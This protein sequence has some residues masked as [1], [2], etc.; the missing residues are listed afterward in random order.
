MKIVFLIYSL[1]VNGISKS[2]LSLVKHIKQYHTDIEV[3]VATPHIGECVKL[4]EKESIRVVHYRSEKDLSS[5]INNGKFKPDL[6]F[7]E[8]LFSLAHDR[9]LTLF[10]CPIILRIHNELP[11]NA[12]NSN[13][14]TNYK[15]PETY[16][17]LL[18]GKCNVLIFTSKH[19]R[20]HYN[21]VLN[22]FPIKYKVIYPAFHILEDEGNTALINKD[23]FN[24]LQLGTIYK[25]KGCIQT[26]EAFN[27]FLDNQQC[28]DAKLFFFGIR[29]ASKSEKDYVKQVEYKI[30]EY[31]LRNYVK[32]YPTILETKSVINNI[33][34]LTLHSE[35][36]SFPLVVLEAMSLGKPIV[37]TDVGGLSE[38]ICPGI[39]GYL[40][41]FNDVFTQARLFQSIYEN[42]YVW[43]DK[44]DEIIKYY[45]NRFNGYN[46]NEKIIKEFSITA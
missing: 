40:F 44:S 9:I 46:Q 29:D 7:I 17:K 28:K 3:L 19:N 26:L 35:S 13:W 30:Q 41:K 20:V 32:L 36:E 37:A 24:I 34:L 33:S 18:Y 6:I 16:F 31:S 2:N 4:F 5:E 23:M 25:R 39:N 21:P 27:I 45:N 12:E 14:F 42:R 22:K 38:Q 15:K 8:S 1:N 11:L 43:K 10:N